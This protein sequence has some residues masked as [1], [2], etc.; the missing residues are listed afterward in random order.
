MTN[1]NFT[2]LVAG[3]EGH[4]ALLEA[5]GFKQKGG[6]AMEW[7]WHSNTSSSS[8]AVQS[9]TVDP[10][11]VTAVLKLAVA[12]LDRLHKGVSAHKCSYL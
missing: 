11:T 3:L 1:A 9:E 5:C 10:E 4:T 8:N 7:S 6:T 12:G 2:T